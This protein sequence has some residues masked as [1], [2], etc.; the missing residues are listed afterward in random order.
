MRFFLVYYTIIY[1]QKSREFTSR[2]F[3]RTQWQLHRQVLII[4][5]P[6]LGSMHSILFLASA[7]IEAYVIVVGSNKLMSL[8]NVK[9]STTIVIAA[10]IF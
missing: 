8:R 9:D 5:T 1:L 4:A 7:Q 3:I 2:V 10:N 6:V